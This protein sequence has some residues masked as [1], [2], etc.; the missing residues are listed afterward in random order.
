MSRLPTIVFNVGRFVRV[1]G[2]EVDSEVGS[3]RVLAQQLFADAVV[4]L[5]L[6]DHDCVLAKDRLG[7]IIF[8]VRADHVVES[9]LLHQQRE[10]LIIQLS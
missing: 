6:L 3:R 9:V 2:N 1:R 7:R 4:H 8:V 5:D 10:P